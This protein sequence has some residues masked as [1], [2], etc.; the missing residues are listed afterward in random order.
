MFDN[1]LDILK[2]LI[3]QQLFAPSPSALAAKLGYKGRST[4]YRLLEGAVKENT[5]SKVW[6]DICKTFGLSD[7]RLVEI[8]IIL[9][10]AKWLSDL[11]ERYPFDKHNSIWME[12]LLQAMVDED[13]SLLPD[14]FNDEAIPLLKELKKSD[15]NIFYG[16]LMLF[17]VKEKRINPY[18]SDFK[19]TLSNLIKK[20]N[21]YFHSVHPEN[22]IA[23]TAIQI[24]TTNSLLEIVS[25]CLWGLVDSPM[26]ILQYYADPLFINTALRQSSVF[27]EWGDISYWHQS[28]THFGK[29]EKLWIFMSRKSDSIYHGSYIVQELK[30]GKDNETF[31]PQKF[32]TIAFWNKEWENDEYDAIVQISRLP[33]GEEEGYPIS[34]ALYKHEEHSNEMFI[35]F[36]NEHENIYNLPHSLKRISFNPTCNQQDKIWSHLV[37]KFDQKDAMEIFSNSLCQALHVEYLEDEY[38]ITDVGLTQNYFSLLIRQEETITAF[39]IKLDSY[40]FLK[41]LSVFEKLVVCKH[42]NKLCIEWPWLGYVIPLSDFEKIEYNKEPFPPLQE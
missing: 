36:D 37:Y 32:Y 14:S 33:F 17:Y 30:I 41:N 35:T 19:N 29:G 9:E 3:Q 25:P 20:L 7:E 6:K 4:I 11:I 38:A 13:Y 18:N 12:H 21:N 26:M 42:N 8:A 28:N 39:R 40:S 16:M 22:E 27:T 10:K 31:I 24:L 15:E 23:Y 1:Q 2:L 34:Y 5:V